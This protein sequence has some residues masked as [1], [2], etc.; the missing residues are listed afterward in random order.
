MPYPQ[1]RNV[2]VRILIA[3]DSSSVRSTLKKVLESEGIPTQ[4]F[5]LDPARANLV[6][7]IK[8]NNRPASRYL[9]PYHLVHG[10]PTREN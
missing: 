8:G 9:T 7:R 2:F 5:A 4:T 1:K 6:A 3:D 10:D